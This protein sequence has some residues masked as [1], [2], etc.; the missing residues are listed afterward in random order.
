VNL[1]FGIPPLNQ[2]DAGATDLRELFTS[3][4]DFTPYNFT[5]INY[6]MGANATWLAMTK[7]MDFSRPDADEVKLRAA[8]TKSEGLPRKKQ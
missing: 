5:K 6:A 3:K 8:I 7:S 4:P 1:I 2:Y